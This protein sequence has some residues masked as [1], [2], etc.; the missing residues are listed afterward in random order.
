MSKL[1][2]VRVL[3][4]DCVVVIV[5]AAGVSAARLALSPGGEF[6]LDEGIVRR[7]MAVVADGDGA[8][9]PAGGPG[10]EGPAV[11]GLLARVGDPVPVRVGGTSWAAERLV[12]RVVAD[13]ADA[14]TGPVDHVVLA[15]P[16]EWR[17]HRRAALRDAVT[18]LTEVPVTTIGA[19]TALLDGG[20]GGAAAG[21]VL[22]LEA[23]AEGFGAHVCA[24]HDDGWQVRRTSRTDWGGDDVDDALLDF[25]RE[26]SPSTW[27]KGGPD[28]FGVRAACATA[29][30]DLARQTAT[31]VDLPDSEPIR[32]V[33]ADL[34]LVVG[35]GV[36]DVVDQLVTDVIGPAEDAHPS[37]VLVTGPLASLPMVV[38]ALSRATGRSVEHVGQEQALVRY[39]TAGAAAAQSAAAAEEPEIGDE[40]D[41]AVPVAPVRPL[42]RRGRGR[43][44]A[45]L[46]AASL[47]AASSVA[48]VTMTD[49]GEDALVAL[50]DGTV[51]RG[52][53]SEGAIGDLADAAALPAVPWGGDSGDGGAAAGAGTATGGEGVGPDAA[54]GPGDPSPTSTRGGGDG[55]AD[56]GK[57]GKDSKDGK[58]GKDDEDDD[59]GTESSSTDP[60]SR[61]DD[62]TGA[63]STSSTD[64]S[65]TTQEP[66]ATSAPDTTTSG[67]TNPSPEE[68]VADTTTPP[69]SEP[70]PSTTAPEPEPSTTVPEPEPEP[71]S[72]TISEPPP[73]EDPGT[74]TTAPATTQ[75]DPSTTSPTTSGQTSPEPAAP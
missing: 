6:L 53:S 12:A 37:L 48:A 47:A 75:A 27:T 64:D 3:S 67:T 9:V 74:S 46:V 24:R 14:V 65:S 38:E 2:G 36:C 57:E 51:P 55:D 15:V 23:G 44:T 10:A 18:A 40:Q 26:R 16:D 50:I 41:T 11:D 19:A 30:E 32:L 31:E 43:R 33:R 17:D 71:T 68:T 56:D 45:I 20:A 22:V 73:S 54:G 7:P 61:E 58:D 25:V 69:T 1:L 28:A 5:D 60:T 63:D 49:A 72:S 52:T 8:P 4:G 29:R 34:E 42:R 62:S 59:T 70:S 39:A 13:A 66:D 21:P 35:A